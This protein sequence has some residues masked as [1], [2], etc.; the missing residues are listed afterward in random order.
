M[1]ASG[2]AMECPGQTGAYI[3][4]RA[5]FAAGLLHVLDH[6]PLSRLHRIP[7]TLTYSVTAIVTHI[8]CVGLPISLMVH[9]LAPR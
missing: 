4:L 9:R 6:V 1:A 5:I 3:A 2:A 7:V 8:I